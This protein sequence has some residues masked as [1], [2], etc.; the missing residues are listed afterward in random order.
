[1][2]IGYSIFKFE[3]HN[4]GL[5]IKDRIETIKDA[6]KIGEKIGGKHYQVNGENNYFEEYENGEKVSWSA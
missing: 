3:D 5:I 4:S 1:M 6:R 2:K